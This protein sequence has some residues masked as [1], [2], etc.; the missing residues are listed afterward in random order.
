MLIVFPDAVIVQTGKYLSLSQYIWD[1]FTDQ[2]SIP[3][4][5]SKTS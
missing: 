4:T 1:S 2:Y 5:S 3:V